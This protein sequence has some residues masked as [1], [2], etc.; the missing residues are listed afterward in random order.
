MTDIVDMRELSQRFSARPLK[1]YQ[2]P[3]KL[4][5][6]EIKMEDWVDWAPLGQANLSVTPER[7]DR[8]MRT[9]KWPLFDPAY[10]AWKQG[11]AL[12]TN[13]TPIGAWPALLPEQ[14]EVL[15]KAGL[16]SIEDIAD[17]TDST[18][19]RIPLPGIRDLVAQAR[20]YLSAKDTTAAA[21]AIKRV[22]E[23][24]EDLKAR[25]AEMEEML[26]EAMADKPRRGRPPKQAAQPEETD[27]SE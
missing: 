7:V 8:C 3:R 23:E 5:N 9:P 6:G 27:D 4:P 14:A 16:A 13:G 12:P 17:L 25:M 21:A 26:K 18:M 11:N 22:N 15:R 20:A 2:K 19:S 1:F 10:Q 24:N